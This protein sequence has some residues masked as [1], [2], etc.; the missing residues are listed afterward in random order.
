M[1]T[2]S[3]ITIFVLIAF[4]FQLYPRT[5]SNDTEPHAKFLTIHCPEEISIGKE[6]EKDLKQGLTINYH[7]SGNDIIAELDTGIEY[8]VSRVIRIDALIL[9]LDKSGNYLPRAFYLYKKNGLG[10]FVD[11]EYIMGTTGLPGAAVFYKDKPNTIGMSLFDPFAKTMEKHT[12]VLA[13]L[14]AQKITEILLIINTVEIEWQLK[15]PLRNVQKD[16]QQ[17]KQ[18]SFNLPIHKMLR[19]KVKYNEKSKNN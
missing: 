4:H 16:S 6:L 11:T 3:L 19:I 5:I 10:S 14:E 15:Y 1:K 17:K 18:G 13:A 12:G 2:S 9:Y 7:F 8:S